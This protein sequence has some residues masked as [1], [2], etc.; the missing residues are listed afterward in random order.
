MSTL[1]ELTPGL[2]SLRLETA[3]DGRVAEVVLTGPGKGNAMGPDMWRELPEV[4]GALDR[5]PAVRAVLVRGEGAHFSYGIDLVAMARELAGAGGPA[6][7]RAGFLDGVRR[8]QAALDAAATCRKPVVAAVDGWC[9]GGGVDLIAAC[10]IR[11]CSAQARFSV[12]EVRV[13]IVADVGSLQRLPYIIGDGTTRRLALTGEDVDAAFAERVGLV[14]E[15]F[16]DGAALLTG[17]RALAC[18]LAENPPLVVQGTKQVL[19]A[20]RDLPL[21]DGLEH[22]AVWNS[23]FLATEDLGEAM[24]AFTERRPPRFTGR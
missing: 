17:A 8:L 21:R 23:A 24:A 20:C 4:F 3:E 10:D 9:I 6:Y 2:K 18:L 19:N 1:A 12:R 14:S 5:D 22:V 15:V 13:G 11:V 7:E 16:A